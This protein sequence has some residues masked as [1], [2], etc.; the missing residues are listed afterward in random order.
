MSNIYFAK[1]YL[2][3]TNLVS[4]S[5][6]KNNIYFLDFLVWQKCSRKSKMDKKN[7]Q[8]LK[9]LGL[10]QTRIFPKVNLHQNAHNSK[11]L[12]QNVLR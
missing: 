8:F 5:R 10:Y 4:L 3:P 1:T 6:F 9:T 12:I 2:K 7:V 11:F